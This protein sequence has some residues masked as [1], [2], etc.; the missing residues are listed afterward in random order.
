VGTY[1]FKGKKNVGQG[2]G[3]KKENIGL[4]LLLFWILIGGSE[5]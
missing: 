4:M 5:V 2:Q 1:E 3:Q